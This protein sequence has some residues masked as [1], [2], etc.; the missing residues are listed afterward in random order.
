MANKSLDELLPEAD[1]AFLQEKYPDASVYEVGNEVHVLLPSFPFPVAYNPRVAN[2]L[3]R[4]PAGYAEVKPDMFWTNPDVKLV[5]GAWPTACEHHEL[6]GSGDGVEAYNNVTWQRWSRH[7]AP[8]DWRSGIDGLRSF[9]GAIK[10]ELERQ[11]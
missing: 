9:V 2:L 1:I 10:N 11:V 8:A 5:S 7:S 3:I 6:P 4:L